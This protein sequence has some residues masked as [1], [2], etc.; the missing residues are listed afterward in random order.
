[1]S[2]QVQIVGT[3]W[4]TDE[5]SFALAWLCD[6]NNS[7]RKNIPL[8]YQVKMFGAGTWHNTVGCTIYHKEE[9]EKDKWLHDRIPVHKPNSVAVFARKPYTVLK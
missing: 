3:G 9:R 5:T 8:L 1:M 7:I 4:M 2:K 6:N